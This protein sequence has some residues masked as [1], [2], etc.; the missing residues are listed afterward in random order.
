M[1]KKTI[2]L[3]VLA[4]ICI[5]AAIF[6]VK[7][8]EVQK[9]PKADNKDNQ[10][11][12]TSNTAQEYTGRNASQDEDAVQAEN[13]KTLS[14][15]NDEDAKAESELPD[16]LS[17]DSDKRVGKDTP[18]YNLPRNIMI[19]LVFIAVLGLAGFFVLK[20]VSPDVKSGGGKIMGVSET[21]NLGAGKTIHI[22]EVGDERKFVI[23]ATSNSVN[24]IAEITKKGGNETNTD[25]GVD[26]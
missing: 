26:Q 3:I 24:L 23:G 17:D 13:D 21:L 2:Y 5:A 19:A 1:K 20:K 18:D 9:T 22:L 25:A 14:E 10:S 6:L 8:S 7:L 4:A 16:Y 15:K 12:L 11:P